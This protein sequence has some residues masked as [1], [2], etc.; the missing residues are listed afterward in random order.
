MALGSM[1]GVVQCEERDVCRWFGEGISA[2]GTTAC[3]NEACTGQF[4]Q[5][6]G[7]VS[8]GEFK[9]FYNRR[10]GSAVSGGKAARIVQ[11]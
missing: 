1:N 3:F 8:F 6:L 5:L 4:L 9:E 11:E 7:E 10:M 2:F